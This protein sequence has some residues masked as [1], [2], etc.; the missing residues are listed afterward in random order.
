MF[1][2]FSWVILGLAAGF[3]LGTVLAGAGSSHPGDIG[4]IFRGLVI[5]LLGGGAAG[6]WLGYALKTRFAGNQRALSGL[7]VAPWIVIGIGVLG[8]I[9]FEAHKNRDNLLASGGRASINYEIR[10]PPGSAAPDVQKVTLEFRT[11]KEL[12]KPP[13]SSVHVERAGDRVIIKSYFE[14]YKTAKKRVIALRVADGP[15][16]LFTLD[17]PERPPLGA[18]PGLNNVRWR[19]LTE[20]DDNVAGTLPRPPQ[21]NENLEIRYEIDMY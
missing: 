10:L 5:G 12:R 4:A 17:L 14:T 19:G 8:A 20:V 13:Y 1:V 15:T 9:G 11:E 21:P 18:G 6:G 2:I 3:L 16:Y 7:G